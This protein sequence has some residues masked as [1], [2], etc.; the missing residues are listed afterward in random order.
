MTD[1]KGIGASGQGRVSCRPKPRVWS[2]KVIGALMGAAVQ[3]AA[4]PASGWTL[5]EHAEFAR[6]AARDFAPTAVA[7]VI[8]NAVDDARTLGLPLC[9]GTGSRF[10]AT[11]LDGSVA[12]C[13]S[14]GTLA[15][16]AGDHADSIATLW[17]SL[18]HPVS[19]AWP[20]GAELLSKSVTGVAVTEWV[21]FLGELPPGVGEVFTVPMRDPHSLLRRSVQLPDGPGKTFVRGIDVRLL[22]VDHD[23]LSRAAG[24]LAHFNFADHAPADVLMGVHRGDLDNALAQMLVHHARSLQLAARVRHAPQADR[25][26]IELEAFLEHTFAVHFMEDGFAAGHMAVDA[27]VTLDSRRKQ[28]H[29]YFD[30]HGVKVVRSMSRERCQADPAPDKDSRHALPICWRA[31]GDGYALFDD[32]LYVA[33]AIARLQTQF[34]MALSPSVAKALLDS[35]DDESGATPDEWTRD[36]VRAAVLLDPHPSW[37]KRPAH[38][39]ATLPL[40]RR[41]RKVI[42]DVDAAL[43][44]LADATLAGVRTV[45]AQTQP[46]SADAAVFGPAS[47]GL[48]QCI[49]ETE[50]P[51]ERKDRRPGGHAQSEPCITYGVIWRPVMLAWPTPDTD[52]SLVEGSDSFDRGFALQGNLMF[53]AS[54]YDTGTPNT[55]DPNALY[56]AV[57]GGMSYRIESLLPERSQVAL[58]EVNVGYAQGLLTGVEGR[59]WV[60]YGFVELRVPLLTLLAAGSS[61]L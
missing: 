35:C 49:V 22:M 57:G 9:A 12:K 37:S 55:G 61:Y 21:R 42:A 59:T 10:A 19:G 2:L 29:D 15:G 51:K 44:H 33:E 48:E 17:E 11:P 58:G 3:L 16:L 5:P 30:R 60:P 32:R 18:T 20:S 7:D 45:S 54:S 14:Y 53:G 4:T 46:S 31:R 26:R 36:C 27:S 39:P 13:V 28:R 50:R 38:T 8:S 1:R 56:A 6:L 23:Y 25:H 47:Q 52:V 43:G 24:T 40:L 34:A 41:A